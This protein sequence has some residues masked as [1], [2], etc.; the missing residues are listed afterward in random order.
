MPNKPLTTTLID[1]GLTENE[2]KVYLA[3]L[4]LGP[5]TILKL[6]QAAETK[7][8]TVYSVVESLKMK[9]L[10]TIEVKGFKKLFVAESPE[11]LET[12]LENR[13]TLLAKTLPEFSALY[14]LKGGESQIKYY[15]GLSGIK[16]V[17]EN[18]IRD[19]RPKEDYSIISHQEQWINLDPEFFLDF[20][21]RR[22]KLNINIRLLVQDSPTAR[23]H[24]RLEKTFNEHIKILPKDTSLNTNLVVIPKKVVIH[25]LT[26]PIM[27]IVI[28]NQS[29]VRMHQQLFE[30]IWRTIPE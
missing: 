22:A 15:E 30:I 7:R 14:N 13:K 17:Y 1:L 24:K 11:K 2:A 9:G 10:I 21:K 6:A 20:T 5:T 19:V 25:Q 8:T 18:L 23:E 12:I 26:P 28:E 27:A 29:V 4:T 16:S 3:A